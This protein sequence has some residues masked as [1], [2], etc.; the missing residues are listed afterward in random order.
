MLHFLQEYDFQVVHRAGNK[1]AN[2]DGLSRML[3]DELPDWQPGKREEALGVCPEAK[4]LEEALKDLGHTKGRGHII[5]PLLGP[6]RN[7]R[8]LLKPGDETRDESKSHHVW[9][10][11][12]GILIPLG[13]TA[14]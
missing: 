9:R 10:G 3:E 1:H 11:G 2:A 7:Q 8:R 4:N 13:R 14:H 12:T 6:R 5:D